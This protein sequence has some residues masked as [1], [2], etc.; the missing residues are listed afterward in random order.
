MV[1]SLMLIVKDFG[2]ALTHY[3]RNSIELC[4]YHSCVPVVVVPVEALIVCPVI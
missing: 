4:S 1:V 2:R 3:N